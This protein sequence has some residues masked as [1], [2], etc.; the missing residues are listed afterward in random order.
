MP[1]QLLQ[2]GMKVVQSIIDRMGRTL[3]ARN[4]TLE[5]YIKENHPSR[6]TKY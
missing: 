6:Q 3:I 5:K 4:S 2:P 1:A